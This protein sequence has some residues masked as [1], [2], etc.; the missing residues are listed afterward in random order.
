MNFGGEVIGRQIY[1]NM[2]GKLT[3]HNELGSLPQ[4]AQER[5]G[6][7]RRNVMEHIYA[8]DGGEVIR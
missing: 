8:F 7:L 3:F 6:N 4:N 5:L 2:K 1:L